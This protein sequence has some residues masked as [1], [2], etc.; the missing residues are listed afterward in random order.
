MT[1]S[2]LL[3]FS[4]LLLIL[5]IV[6]YYQLDIPAIIYVAAHQTTTIKLVGTFIQY[7]FTFPL[8]A[9]ISVIGLII[10]FIRAGNIKVFMQRP[11]TQ[12]F[13]ALFL[14]MFFAGIL[15][16]SLGRY[17]P[18]MYLLHNLYGFSGFAFG[19]KV[20]NSMPSDHTAI[21]FTLIT[22]LFY[23]MRSLGWRILIVL[24][25]LAL[26][27]MRVFYLKHY[28]SDV[29]IGILVGVWGAYLAHLFCQHFS[30]ER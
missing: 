6:S 21:I 11:S 20:R 23:F 2:R 19:E 16:T 4:V 25:G 5:A 17:R 14:T 26:V 24:L 18:E 10:N 7:A 9:A 3:V 12:F 1:F 15:K 22:T 27:A 28:P 30:A 13:L 8:W 29:L